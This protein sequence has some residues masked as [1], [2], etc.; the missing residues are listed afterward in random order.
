MPANA[1]PVYAVNVL[2]LTLLPRL[3]VQLLLTDFASE[4]YRIVD[5]ERGRLDGMAVVL[6]GPAAQDPQRV[7]ALV[8][9]LVTTV[10]RRA[11]RPIRVYRQGPRGGWTRVRKEE[12]RGGGHEG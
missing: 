10:S 12:E 6:N 1:P 3:I 11:G 7:A 9:L 8:D 2:D 5:V 4:G